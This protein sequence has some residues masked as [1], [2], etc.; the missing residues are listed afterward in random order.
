MTKREKLL[1]AKMLDLADEEF[2]NH[3][4]NDV[5]ED[6]WDGWTIGQRRKFMKEF[7]YWN[8]DPE[9][10]DKDSLDLPDFCLMS[11]LSAKLVKEC[12]KK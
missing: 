11:F 2:G 8:G 12:E 9:E 7:H 1:T 3:G 4:C 10:Y 5:D 6:V